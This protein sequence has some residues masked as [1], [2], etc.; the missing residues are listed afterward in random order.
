MGPLGIGEFCEVP[1]GSPFLYRRG[2]TRQKRVSKAEKNLL[3]VPTAAAAYR[4]F[5]GQLALSSPPHLLRS[6]RPPVDTA[7]ALQVHI[8][9][10]GSAWQ[11]VPSLHRAPAHGPL[12]QVT[13]SVATPTGAHWVVPTAQQ[14]RQSLVHAIQKGN[15]WYNC[16]HVLLA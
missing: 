6:L 16:E 14:S 13:L 5:Q 2:D 12:L 9:G 10:P 3:T 8:S 7:A 15:L 1:C 11:V 4:S